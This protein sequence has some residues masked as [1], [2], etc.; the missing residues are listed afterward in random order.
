MFMSI[1]EVKCPPSR[2]QP[3]VHVE[4]P[5]V[6]TT[7]DLA[8]SRPLLIFLAIFSTLP[9]VKVSLGCIYEIRRF[10]GNAEEMVRQREDVV[11][12]DH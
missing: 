1:R 6:A 12:I 10:G 4:L 2:H 11:R 3:L 5:L 7:A 8:L 9:F